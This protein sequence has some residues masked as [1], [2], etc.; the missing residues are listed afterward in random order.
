MRCIFCKCQS[1]NSLSAEHIFPESLGNT[2]H[3]LA[4]GIVCDTCNNYFG[5][6]VEHPFLSTIH[7]RN[8]RARK[9]LKNK[10]GKIPAHRGSIYGVGI[11]IDLN[12]DDNSICAAYDKHNDLFIS[13]FLSNSQVQLILP[14]SCPVEHQIISRFLAKLAIEMLANRLSTVH[15]W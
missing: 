7:F 1:D 9:K 2:E 3:I 15:D 10:R 8:L 13:Y 4:P 12:L 6:K 5:R 11:E 14:L